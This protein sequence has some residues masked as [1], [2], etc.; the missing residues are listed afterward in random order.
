M[1]I[2]L[3]SPFEV[4]QI[5]LSTYAII[6]ILMRIAPRIG[7][8]D[9]P[10]ERKRHFGSIPLVG[11]AGIFLGAA[12]FLF[13]KYLYSDHWTGVHE[14][15]GIF[16][17]FSLAFAVLGATDD[18]IDL[19]PKIKLIGQ[20]LIAFGLLWTQPFYDLAIQD[21][22]FPKW[23]SFCILTLF[24]TGSVNA[25]NMMDG[26]DGLA[27]GVASMLLSA[28]MIVSLLSGAVFSFVIC[29]AFL[30]SVLAFLAL[31]AQ[32]PWRPRAAVFLGDAG[33]LLLGFVITVASIDLMRAEKVWLFSHLVFFLAFPL[34]E[35]ITV[36]IR[37][38]AAGRHPFSADRWHMHHLMLDNDIPPSTMAFI[39]ASIN[40]LLAAIA[41]ILHVTDTNPTTSIL[42]FI[43]LLAVHAFAINRLTNKEQLV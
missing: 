12:I 11:G 37:R 39:I 4:T 21:Y 24:I 3:V 30:G 42:L 38:I 17:M 34:F 29:I 14:K 5:T 23:A 36:S 20:M 27:G 41:F 15:I 33:S 18:R 8:V 7:F 32:T 1:E 31:N 28:L 43:C 35:M 26:S 16:L 10:S 40:G 6:L 22:S 13:D 9:T 25:F 2:N 19:S